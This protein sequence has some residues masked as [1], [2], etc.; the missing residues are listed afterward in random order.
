MGVTSLQLAYFLGISSFLMQS[1]AA[2]QLFYVGTLN[3]FQVLSSHQM[4][5][6]LFLEV[7]TAL[8]GS[9]MCKLGVILENFITMKLC[10]MFPSQWTALGL[11]QHH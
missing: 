8:S 10:V 1:Q 4:E 9:G 5:N 11:L 3:M 2:R 6:Y 7:M